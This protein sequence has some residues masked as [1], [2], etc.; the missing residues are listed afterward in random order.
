M[1]SISTNF[2]SISLCLGSYLHENEQIQ[3]FTIF[4]HHDQYKIHATVLL[5]LFHE[6]IML[7]FTTNVG[8]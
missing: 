4:G 6:W 8:I 1:G 2:M 5:L 3:V 7:G